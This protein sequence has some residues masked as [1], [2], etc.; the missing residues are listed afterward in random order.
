MFELE[1][2]YH[3]MLPIT[4]RSRTRRKGSIDWFLRKELLVKERMLEPKDG[5]KASSFCVRVSV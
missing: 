3:P 5:V 1:I 2:K 4:L